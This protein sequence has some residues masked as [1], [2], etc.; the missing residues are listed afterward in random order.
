MWFCYNCVFFTW[1]IAR[2]WF[3]VLY[4][5]AMLHKHQN[6]CFNELPNKSLFSVVSVLQECKKTFL[7]FLAEIFSP[8]NCNQ[9]KVFIKKKSFPSS[10]CLLVFKA[11]L[12]IQCKVNLSIDLY[13]IIRA[14]IIMSVDFKGT[15]PMTN[16]LS[17]ARLILFNI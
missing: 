17:N 11:I 1:F 15:C 8:Y 12:K 5:L 2:F 13:N 10:S 6:R 9:I 7:C 16:C 4:L 3:I 14:F